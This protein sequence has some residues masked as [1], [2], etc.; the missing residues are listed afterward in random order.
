MQFP[1]RLTTPSKPAPGVFTSDCS[2][3]GQAAAVNSDGTYNSAER[4]AVPGSYLTFYITG[5]GAINPPGV[6]GAAAPAQSTIALPVI[7]RIAGQEARIVYAVAAPGE[8]YGLAAVEVLVPADLPYGGA[9]PLVVQVGNAFGQANVTVSVKDPPAP[10]PGDPNGLSAALESNGWVTLMWDSD[11][12]S[13]TRFRIEQRTG[14]QEYTEV[15]TAPVD[16][17]A[18][19]DRTVLPGTAYRIACERKTI[20]RQAATRMKL[21]SRRWPP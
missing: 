12:A 7:V 14:L 15:A 9:L 20:G 18:F 13:A 8:V 19:T 21:G 10:R 4:P 3:T 16:E 1:I 11:G 2:G 5:E 6:D 17:L